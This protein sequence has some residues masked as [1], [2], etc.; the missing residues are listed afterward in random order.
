MFI[1]CSWINVSFAREKIQSLSSK[2]KQKNEIH[3]KKN[4]S[5]NWMSF[6]LNCFNCLQIDETLKPI[7]VVAVCKRLNTAVC[8]GVNPLFVLV[9]PTGS[10]P[11]RIDI[12]AWIHSIEWAISS[13]NDRI[14]WIWC[15]TICILPEKT[16][17]WPTTLT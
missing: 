10:P 16:L 8:I 9:V 13:F 14:L 1:I 6:S 4:V 2:K 11:F 5:T 7:D 12:L 3:F 15:A 17:T